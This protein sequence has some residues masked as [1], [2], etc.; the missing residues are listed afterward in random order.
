M[1]SNYA[2]K[3]L[4]NP[5]YNNEGATI[6]GDDDLH[7]EI[8]MKEKFGVRQPQ[9]IKSIDVRKSTNMSQEPVTVAR[10]KKNVVLVKEMR[11]DGGKNLSIEPSP[12]TV[13]GPP[14]DFSIF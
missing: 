14:A 13:V 5:R 7:Q 9:G 1:A 8:L 2:I 6:L 4:N 12:G 10:M 11:A 3:E